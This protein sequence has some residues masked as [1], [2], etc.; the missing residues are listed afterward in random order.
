MANPK[1]PTIKA[2]FSKIKDPRVERTKLHQLIE[3]IIIA[4][5][6]VISGA[7]GWEDIAEYGKAKQE[8]LKTFLTLEHGIPCDDTFRR[9]FSR[10]KPAE[11]AECFNS[12]ITDV[13]EASK[14][15][16]IAIDGK[17]L[18]RSFD[19]AS[20]KA[21]IHMVS[22][23]AKTNR[24]VLGQLKV[25]EKSNE[26]TAIPKLLDMLE[27]AGCIVTIDAMG[28][29]KDIAAKIIEKE[30]DYVLALKANQGKL[31]QDTELFF[32]MATQLNFNKI[33]HKVQHTKEDSHG[34]QEVRS[35]WSVSVN[36]PHLAALI[37]IEQWKNLNS[38]T[39][40]K[41]ERTIGDKTTSETRY[42]ISSI[43]ASARKIGDAIRGHWSI[44]NSLHWV[45][46]V[47][48]NED[49]SRIRK[50]HA[51]ENFAVLRHIALNLLTKE[52]TAKVGIKAKRKRAGWDDNYLLKVL[53]I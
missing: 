35:V 31:Y 14:G 32:R 20:S 47:A 9:V 48:F 52:S 1:A 4:I 53:C 43:K 19:R 46:D 26:I 15:E 30:A 8:W 40:V 18:R 36:E 37:N 50:D 16:I 29:Q 21:A 10:I 38:V 7:E 44:E 41:S 17:Q 23:W 2:H 45:L 49:S 24:L 11:F 28:C 39:M 33:N 22:A 3:I 6:A 42:Y 27:V 12:W 51:A 34:R 13:K 5:C 25:D